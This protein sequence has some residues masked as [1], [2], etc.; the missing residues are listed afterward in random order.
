M[1]HI[2]G[3]LL[4]SGL[5]RVSLLIVKDQSSVIFRLEDALTFE[6]LDLTERQ[7]AWYGKGSGVVRPMLKWTTE[8]IASGSDVKQSN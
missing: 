5:H 1:C 6:V 2:P 3:N 4:N 8:H 7:G